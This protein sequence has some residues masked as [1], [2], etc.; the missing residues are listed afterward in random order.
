MYPRTNYEM[1]DKQLD[2]LM[3]ACKPVVCMAIGGVA[4]SSPQENANRAWSSLGSEMGFDSL[5]VQSRE[6]FGNLHFSA[7]PSLNN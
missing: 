7:I 6:G 2:N 3:K 5:T 1:T 4:P